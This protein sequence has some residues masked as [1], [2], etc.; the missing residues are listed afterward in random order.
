MPGNH[1]VKHAAPTTTEFAR[2]S[3]SEAVTLTRCRV[4]PVAARQGRQSQPAPEFAR[5]Q[6]GDAAKPTRRQACLAEGRRGTP[7]RPEAGF[8]W[9]TRRAARRAPRLPGS[10]G[11]RRHEARQ[12]PRQ[13]SSL[14]NR[15]HEARRAQRERVRPGIKPHCRQTRR[16]AGFA[17]R[18]DGDANAIHQTRRPRPQGLPRDPTKFREEGHPR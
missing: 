1:E 12:M 18:L 13:P 9:R 14:G 2:G 6:A 5:S 15:T 7:N 8:A 3:E 11:N 16:E 4:R 10:P 17:L